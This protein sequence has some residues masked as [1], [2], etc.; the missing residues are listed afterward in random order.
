M[1]ALL[2]IGMFAAFC[3][4]YFSRTISER[5]SDPVVCDPDTIYLKHDTVFLY[6]PDG[7]V[8]HGYHE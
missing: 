7:P 6:V 3:G 4:G 8:M 2:I 1:R 5:L